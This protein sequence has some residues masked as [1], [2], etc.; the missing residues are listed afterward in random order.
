MKN[1]LFSVAFFISL[2]LIAQWQPEDEYYAC[3]QIKTLLVQVDKHTVRVTRFYPDGT[4]RETGFY[5][6][7]H[8]EG[9]WVSYDRNGEKV[10]DAY[11]ERDRKA[12]TWFFW[13]SGRLVGI[14]NYFN[15]YLVM[16]S[17]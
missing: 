14:A 17:E 16:A 12:G 5:H 9:H 8:M 11:Y 4:V 1:L 15:D 2:P 6:K 10:T 7:G 13:Q 3:G